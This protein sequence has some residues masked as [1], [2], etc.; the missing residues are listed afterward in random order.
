MDP[1]ATTGITHLVAKPIKESLQ[2]YCGV[3]DPG[4]LNFKVH[5]VFKACPQPEEPIRFALIA[6]QETLKCKTQKHW[7]REHNKKGIYID[8]RNPA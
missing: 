1:E 7:K 6:T 2:R 3:I 4:L 8:D 5:F